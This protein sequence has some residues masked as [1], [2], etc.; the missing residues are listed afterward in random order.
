MCEVRPQFPSRTPNFQDV[1]F[2]TNLRFERVFTGDTGR[3]IFL[4]DLLILLGMMF[5]AI[6]DVE[7]D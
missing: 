2:I 5:D 6:V 7:A 3:F 1:T 4:C